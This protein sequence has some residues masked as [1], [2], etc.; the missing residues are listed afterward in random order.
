MATALALAGC[1]T[2]AESSGTDGVGSL[3]PSTTDSAGGETQQSTDPSG[4][5]SPTEDESASQGTAGSTADHTGLDTTGEPT[6]TLPGSE[7]TAEPFTTTE[8]IGPDDSSSGDGSDEGTDGTAGTDTTEMTGTTGMTEPPCVPSPEVCND[9][10]DDCNDIVDDLDV[11]MDGICDCL[12][13]A[14]VGNQ[15]AN[16]SSK[17]QLYLEEQGTTV[18]R[19]NSNV[20]MDINTPITPESLAEYDIVI[21]DWLQRTYQPEEAEAVRLWVEAGAGLM[22]MTGHTNNQ[23]TIDRSNSFI[24]PLGLKYNGSKGFFNG[25]ITQFAPHPITEGLTSITFLGGLYI[26]VTPDDVG[27]NT[28]IMTLPQG[29]V[30]VAQE[31]LEGRVFVFGDEWVEFDSEWQNQPQIKQFWVQTLAY[32]G[33]KNACIVPK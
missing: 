18:E 22:T 5:T 27:T 20:M 33:P 31:R 15:G 12:S 4:I 23:V 2:V 21:L 29:P 19:I 26:D 30:G 17:F 28:T 13:I 8:P 14:L 11:G 6:T 10:D 16:A 3:G 32:L 25:P 7:T 24:A 1:S 9:L